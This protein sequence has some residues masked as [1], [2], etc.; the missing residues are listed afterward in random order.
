MH[1][2][3]ALPARSIVLIIA[4]IKK[5]NNSTIKVSLSNGMALIID[6]T[7]TLRPLIEVIARKGRST[8][9]ALNEFKL[10]PSPS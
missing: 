7:I 4:K 5:K 2:Y 9:S 1:I 6:K 10:K 3:L 8:L